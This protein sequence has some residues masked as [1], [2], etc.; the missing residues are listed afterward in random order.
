MVYDV[1]NSHFLNEDLAAAL[2]RCRKRLKLMDLSETDQQ[3]YSHAA[4]PSSV[5]GD[6]TA[7]K[8]PGR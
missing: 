8:K 6:V 2:R 3:A 7:R 1:A 4:A 5:T